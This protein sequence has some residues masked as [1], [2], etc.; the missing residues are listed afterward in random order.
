MCK[1][2]SQSCRPLCDPMDSSVHRILKARILEWIAISFSI[3]DN[4]AGPKMPLKIVPE[5]V[6]T[7]TCL[8]AAGIVVQKP[9]VV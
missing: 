9:S 7:T 8:A 4:L 6:E 3:P 1:S 2:G 5:N